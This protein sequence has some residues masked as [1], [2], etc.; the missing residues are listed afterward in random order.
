MGRSST[1]P[2]SIACLEFNNLSGIGCPIR[3]RD[4]VSEREN[5]EKREIVSKKEREKEERNRLGEIAKKE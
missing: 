4:R 2:S 1:A 5:K 3:A